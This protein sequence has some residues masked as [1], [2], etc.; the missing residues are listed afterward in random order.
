MY[1]T[2]QDD[3]IP[4]NDLGEVL[5]VVNDDDE[6]EGF[7]RRVKFPKALPQTTYFSLLQGTWS[8]KAYKL[9]V[10]DIQKKSF[11]HVVKSGMD[12]EAIGESRMLQREQST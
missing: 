12:P 1:W 11:V 4:R 8:L 2:E 10:S 3:D 7:R 5:E 6:P 9:N